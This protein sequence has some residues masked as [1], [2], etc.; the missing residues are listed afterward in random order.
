VN[1]VF[2]PSTGPTIASI[3]DVAADQGGQLQIDWQRNSLDVA[4][5]VAPI[6]QYVIQRLQG[7]TWIDV[8]TQA[9]T[10][11]ASYS[12][13]VVTPDIASPA[14]PE[15]ASQYRIEA[16]EATGFARLSA[17]SSGYSID[18]LAPPAP[19]V[20][21][22]TDEVPWVLAWYSPAIPDF[23]H[24]C[25]FRGDAPGF[26][27]GAALWC[28]ANSPYL[29]S[30]TSTHYYVVQFTDTHGNQGAFSN[31]VGST[32]TDA[33]PVFVVHTGIDRVYPNPFNP[34][35]SVAF[36][37]ATQAPARIDVFTP[38]GRLVRTLLDAG[39]GPGRFEVRWD[40]T[41]ASGARAANGSYLVRL[42]SLG[43]VD[44][45]KVLLVK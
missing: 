28:N 18:N 6:S 5:S 10:H 8:A 1:A 20:T 40:G 24:A 22:D 12:K 35:A 43:T 23:D 11:A 15:P 13:L 41:D 39:S 25:V 27:P 3:A 2:V 4:N 29:E 26:T 36:S 34:S 42:Q 44:T 38:D 16:I 32:A 33:P 17:T 37:L 21:L 30:D 19:V 7:G 31:E 45:R 9:A 14:N